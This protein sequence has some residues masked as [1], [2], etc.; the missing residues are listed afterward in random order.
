MS[1]NKKWRDLTTTEKA[2][3]V[4]RGIVQ[5]A[6]LAAALVDIHRRPAE[7]INGSKWVWSA[8]ALVNFIVFGPLAYFRFGRKRAER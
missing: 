8:V 2:P 4:L 6:L 3:L 5:F 7:E 1:R